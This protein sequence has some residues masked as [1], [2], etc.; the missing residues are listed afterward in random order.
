MLTEERHHIILQLL[1]EKEIVKLHEMVE[2]TNA[3]ESTIRRDL[4]Y[5][6]K[7]NYVK[8][9]HGGATRVTGKL[10]EPDMK[11]KSTKNLQAKKVI[12]KKAASLVE[13]GDCIYLDAG[14]TTLQMIDFLNTDY[15]IVVVTNGLGHIEPLLK[16][17]I[18]TYLVGGYVKPRTGALI[19]SGA[20]DS[21][22][23]YRF[24]KCFLGANGVHPDL[25]IT[26]PD[27]DEAAMKRQALQLSRET[28][29]LVDHTK[30]HEI[31]FAKIANLEEVTIITDDA[32][33][34][35][36][37]FNALTNIKVVE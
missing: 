17:G 3:S 20:I 10:I 27:P 22:K 14:S 25:G 33:E 18:K 21:I 26:T 29:L 32:K 35:L 34:D 30:F 37:Q 4:T 28:F 6:E 23:Q 12:A 8:R 2:A 16:K 13:D 15:D 24:D 1:K 31:S 7:N 19:G 5:L 11:E 9:V 36:K